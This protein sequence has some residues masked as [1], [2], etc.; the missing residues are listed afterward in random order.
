MTV[1]EKI[2]AIK[3]YMA[4][5]RGENNCPVLGAVIF[6]LNEGE[7]E[8][9]QYKIMLDSDKFSDRKKVLRFLDTLGLISPEYQERLNRWRSW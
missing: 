6:Y 1:T 7:I 2:A 5:N 9:A 8:Q 4:E 3:Q